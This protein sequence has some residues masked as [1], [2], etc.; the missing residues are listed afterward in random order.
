MGRRSCCRASRSG[1]HHSY[2]VWI[3]G[4]FDGPR[5]IPSPEISSA[6]AYYSLGPSFPAEY[7]SFVLHQLGYWDGYVRPITYVLCLIITDS[8]AMTGVLY[9]VDIYFTL[10]KGYSASKAG[11]QLLYYT[12]GI[13]GGVYSMYRISIFQILT[14]LKNCVNT[15]MRSLEVILML[16][17]GHVHVQYISSTNILSTVPWQHCRSY[18]N[19]CPRVGT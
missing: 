15:S 9:F 5:Q 2:F 11:I 6:E 8:L 17:S 14:L 13:G 19:Y 4:I 3:L 16:N 1:F 12:P 7:G 10:V 18:R